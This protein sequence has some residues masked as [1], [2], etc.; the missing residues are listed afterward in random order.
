[1]SLNCPKC[2][3]NDLIQKVSH[4]Y[5]S[6]TTSSSQTGYVS[7]IGYANGGLAS[8][9]GTATMSG[10]AQTVLARQL[11]PP[12]QPKGTHW[13]WFIM[14]L[15]PIWP[16]NYFVAFAAPI[17]KTARL[18][19]IGITVAAA[20]VFGVFR[21]KGFLMPFDIAVLTTPIIY[22]VGLIRSAQIRSAKSVPRWQ[23]AMLRWEQLY[24]CSRDAC[25][26]EPNKNEFLPVERMYELLNR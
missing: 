3:R 12:S 7:G 16:I 20:I 15:I 18:M 19:L 10:T 22:Y 2:G 23:E 26:F 24:Y 6:G 9:G 21:V 17:G 25:V 5:S 11:A 1:M 4:I 14:P 8:M 13:F